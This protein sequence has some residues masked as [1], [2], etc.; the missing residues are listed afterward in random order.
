VGQTIDGIEIILI[1]EEAGS[2]NLPSNPN[3]NVGTTLVLDAASVLNYESTSATGTLTVLGSD[4]DKLQLNLAANWV[5]GAS[6]TDAQNQTLVTW[7]ATSNGA[8][9][10]VDSQVQV[11]TV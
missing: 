5:Q 10:H 4:G 1:T 11:V 3:D 2:N 6:V 9:V 8:T 7:T